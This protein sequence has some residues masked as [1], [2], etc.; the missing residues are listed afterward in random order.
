M[1]FATVMPRRSLQEIM[2]SAVVNALSRIRQREKLRRE[3]NPRKTGNKKAL[4]QK[5]KNKVI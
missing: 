1:K 3:N 5:N 4:H 2:D